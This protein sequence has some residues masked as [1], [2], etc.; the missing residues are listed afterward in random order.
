MKQTNNETDGSETVKHA[1]AEKHFYYVRESFMQSFFA[2]L[3]SFGWFIAFALLNAY[4]LGD[5]WYFDVF[6]IVIFF[7]MVSAKANTRIH[8]FYTND[9]LIRYLRKQK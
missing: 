6:I 2:D 3:V 1:N 4:V 9:E 5:K 7:I 8:R